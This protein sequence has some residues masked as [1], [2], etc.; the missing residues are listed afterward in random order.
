M[1]D[2]LIPDGCAFNVAKVLSG[3]YSG[4]GTGT[5][6]DLELHAVYGLSVGG[7]VSVERSAGSVHDSN[8]LHPAQ[9]EAGTLYIWVLGYNS[10]ERMVEAVRARAH[11]L[12]RLEKGA[13]GCRSITSGE[14]Q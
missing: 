14:L 4:T 5:E 1:R 12:Q 2:V 11:V 7:C 3:L 6:A 8:G 10:Y 13:N 9:W